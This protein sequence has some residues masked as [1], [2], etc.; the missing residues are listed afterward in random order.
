MPPQTLFIHP[1]E[2]DRIRAQST[3]I[4][5]TLQSTTGTKRLTQSAHALRSAAIHADLMADFSLSSLHTSDVDV[6]TLIL[7][8]P[9]PPC[10][11]AIADLEPMTLSELRMHTH[12]RG[13]VLTVT[14]SSPVVKRAES[15]WVVVKDRAEGPDHSN[16][17]SDND[18][19]RMELYLHQAL[20]EG[21]EMLEA[22]EVFHVKEPFFTLNDRGEQTVR[23]DHPSDLVVVEQYKLVD[24]YSIKASSQPHPVKSRLT[25]QTIANHDFKKLLSSLSKGKPHIAAADQRNSTRV[26]SSPGRGRGLF[27][28]GAIKTGDIVLVEKAFCT[29]APHT[30]L[31]YSSQDDIIRAAPLGLHRAV[32][33]KLMAN[34]GQIESVLDLYS[35]EYAGVGK[36]LT[37]ADGRPVLDAFRVAEIIARNAFGAGGQFGEEDKGNASAGLWI[38]ASYI[39]HSCLPNLTHSVQGDVLGFRACRDIAAGEEL[40]HSYDSTP[41]L[42][43]RRAALA[44]QWDFECECA[45]CVAEDADGPEVGAKRQR[46]VDD[47]QRFVK[48]E[49]AAR[50]KRVAVVRARRMAAAL[51]GTYDEVRYRELPRKA[52]GEIQAWLARAPVYR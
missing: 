9:Y 14:I 36:K 23:V 48:S 22:G 17:D 50:A 13:K 21:V 27:A 26:S 11:L 8:S 40:L 5:L 7:R 44:R 6:T 52:M 39:N 30:A 12:H 2:V 33:Q 51:G 38:R 46:L 31:F 25:E 34:P 47:V 20:H 3:R 37:M 45:L 28:T 43:A 32:L 41:D 42:D 35:G 49:E 19:E 24:D 1:K 15:S 29:A 16:G 18:G 10:L 4:Q